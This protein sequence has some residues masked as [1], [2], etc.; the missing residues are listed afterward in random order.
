VTRWVSIEPGSSG[1]GCAGSGSTGA[2]TPRIVAADR[3]SRIGPAHA[4]Q[5]SAHDDARAVGRPVPV[6]RSARDGVIR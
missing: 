1:S 5:A 6:G 3:H 4:V 2:V